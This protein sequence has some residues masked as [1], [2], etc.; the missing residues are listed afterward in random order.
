M[1]NKLAKRIKFIIK[2]ANGPLMLNVGCG[3]DY[4]EGWVNIDNNSDNNIEKLDLNWD[5]R[6]PLPF[7]ENSVDFIFNEHFMEHLTVE[8]GQAALK[9]F[10]R[11]LKPGGIL[12]IAMPDLEAAVAFYND[13]NWKKKSF[14][15]RFGLEFVETRAELLNMNFRWWGHQW[16]YDWDELERRLKQAGCTKYRRCKL[17]KSKHK[18]LNNLEI[19][20]ESILIAEVEK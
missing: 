11:V 17:R 16:L 6:K 13:K 2:K 1:I 12:R 20:E 14:I 15:K 8:E 9:D 4:K 7:E 10:M 18:E 19:R 3:T 5:L